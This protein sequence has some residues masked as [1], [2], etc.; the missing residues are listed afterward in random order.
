[1]PGLKPALERSLS[2]GSLP[3]TSPIHSRSRQKPPQ[4]TD[5]HFRSR[6]RPLDAMSSCCRALTRLYF[7]TSSLELP[8]VHACRD[9][10]HFAVATLQLKASSLCSPGSPGSFEMAKPMF[11][12]PATPHPHSSKHQSQ[13]N[14]P[15]ITSSLNFPFPI[16]YSRQRPAYV[17]P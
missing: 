5:A 1:M 15:F 3:Q 14:G 10:L 17:S 9:L 12:L 7:R 6:T 4:S 2:S 8:Q 13:T 11:A 16:P